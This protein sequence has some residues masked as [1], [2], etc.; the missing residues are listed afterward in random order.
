MNDPTRL[1]ETIRRAPDF[2]DEDIVLRTKEVKSA[3]PFRV[4]SE[5]HERRNDWGTVS[6]MSSVKMRFP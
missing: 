5:A 6:T 3:I 4:S 2:Q 1:Q